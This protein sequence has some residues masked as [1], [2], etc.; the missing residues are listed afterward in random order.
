MGFQLRIQ[1][2]KNLKLCANK[3]HTL[4]S[5]TCIDDLLDFQCKCPPER[6]GKLCEFCECQSKQTLLSI[7]LLR[8]K[9]EINCLQTLQQ[10][11]NKKQFI[12]LLDI[13]CAPF[14]TW[15]GLLPDSAENIFRTVVNYTCARG[16]FLSNGNVSALAVCNSSAMWDPPILDCRGECLMQ[17]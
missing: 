11:H 10:K 1:Y 5:G 14:P 15:R 17:P 9:K 16:D 2:A 6:K 12:S 7:S 13:K 4:F 8:D 3:V